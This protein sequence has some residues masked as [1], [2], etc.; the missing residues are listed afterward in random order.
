MDPSL[1]SSPAMKESTIT[2]PSWSCPTEEQLAAYT[3]N[4]LAE[5]SR[6]RIEVHVSKCAHCLGHVA[7]LLKVGDMQAPEVPAD[8]LRRVQQPPVELPRSGLIWRWA[9]VGAI[10]ASLAI[11]VSIAVRQPEHPLPQ[12]PSTPA[13]PAVLADR[14]TGQRLPGQM[15]PESQPPRTPARQT[16][17]VNRLAAA[18]LLIA[19]KAGSVV[20][21]KDFEL[22]WKDVPRALF[23]EVRIATSE[24]SLVWKARVEQTSLRLPGEIQLRPGQSYF[25]WVRAY[26]PEGKVV[27][28]EASPFSVHE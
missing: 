5:P 7:F 9:P 6:Q 12:L 3:E 11:A 24:G 13:A 27:R 25:V 21:R 15:P 16:R 1:P 20:D 17:S 10:A 2:R 4:R 18:P 8:L 28:T 23:Y 26:L 22:R 19:P 14:S